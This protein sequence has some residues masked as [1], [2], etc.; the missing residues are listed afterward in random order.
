[1]R[2]APGFPIFS[3]INLIKY[4]DCMSHILCHF[5]DIHSKYPDLVFIEVGR[6]LSIYQ[7]ILN[8][9]TVGKSDFLFSFLICL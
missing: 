9:N 5:G 7:A 2:L 1:M 6:K 3:G 8:F 4:N